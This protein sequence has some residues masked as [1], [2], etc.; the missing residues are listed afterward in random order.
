MGTIGFSEILLILGVAIV[1]L[2]PKRLPEIARALGR[3]MAEFR[4]ASQEMTHSLEEQ[5]T[6]EENK[7]SPHPPS[8]QPCQDETK[9]SV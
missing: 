5:K 9:I 8:N 1:V 4:K 2:G 3:G 6:E 7:S